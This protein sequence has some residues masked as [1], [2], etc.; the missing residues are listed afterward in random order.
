MPTLEIVDT[1]P[2]T[3]PADLPAIWS[4][5]RAKAEA[6]KTTA[7]TLTVTSLDDKANMRLARSTRLSLRD[8]RLGFTRVHKELKAD[9]LETCKRL[10]EEKRTLLALVEPL[11]S[12]MLYME[13]FEERVEAEAKSQRQHQREEALKPYNVDMGLYADLGAMSEEQWSTVLLNAQDN[14]KRALEAAEAAAEVERERAKRQAEI[15]AENAKLRAEN[16]KKD[17]EQAAERARLAALAKVEAEKVAAL[18]AEMRAKEAA[19]R[20]ARE[21]EAEAKRK[22]EAAPDREKLLKMAE[23]L[24][25]MTAP[26][27]TTDAGKDLVMK[28]GGKV[29]WLVAWIKEEVN[30]L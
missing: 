2:P 27:C 5:F 11:E 28:I 18:E 22:A 19:E 13:Q 24:E 6:L 10:D 30:K 20:A 9:A 12:R 25:S 14:H 7:E 3:K 15:E 16:A 8:I 23:Q 17:A 29:Q 1:L 4:E 26:E 21:V